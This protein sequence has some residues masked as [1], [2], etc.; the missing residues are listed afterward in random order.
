MPAAGVSGR[1][2][3]DRSL[4]IVLNAA[5]E[6]AVSSFWRAGWRFPRFREVI[7]QAMDAHTPEP[8]ATLAEVRGRRR[9]G[10]VSTRWS[11]VRS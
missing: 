1:C 11:S 7:A 9:L 5:N 6:V 2:E 4:P 3:A 8:A 10:P